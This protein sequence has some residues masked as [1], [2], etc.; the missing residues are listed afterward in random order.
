MNLSFTLG[1]D[2]MRIYKKVNMTVKKT[3]EVVCNMCGENILKN[4]DGYFNDHLHIEKDW[5]YHSEKD[6]QFDCFD[7]CEKCYDKIISEFTIKPSHEK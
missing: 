2:F 7:L 1:S 3:D 4:K 5:G 6:L